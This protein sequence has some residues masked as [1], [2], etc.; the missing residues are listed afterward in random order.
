VKRLA[1]A[2]L[3]GVLLWLA[4]A[5]KVALE[6]VH[7]GSTVILELTPGTGTQGIAA[8]LE[9][10]GVLRSRWPFLAWHLAKLRSRPKLKA[11]EY[12][13]EGMVGFRDV[14]NKI[15]RG[16]ILYHPVSVPEGFNLYDVAAA[17]DRSGLA[18]ADDF[19]AAARNT[20]LIS[21]LAPGASSLEGFLF[22]DTYLFS[23]HTSASQMVQTMVARFRKVYGEVGKGD[24]ALPGRVL[25]VVT[26]ASLVEK[27]TGKPEE[28]PVVAGVFR[29]RLERGMALQ[30][31]PTVVYAALLAGSYRGT[32]YAS[33]LRRSSPYNTYVARGLPPGP[34]SNPGRAALEAAVRPARTDF[35]YFVA[36]SD[37]GHVFSRTLAEH[38]R[39][40]TSYRRRQNGSA[41]AHG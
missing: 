39:R 10:A 19:L 8:Q 31:D 41:H 13:F 22:P 18:K 21:D 40:V 38:N 20:A 23:R 29:N 6:P 1:I 30:C 33:D 36:D 12:R 5:G 14:Y 34:V 27:E 2:I 32:I 37:G 15:V 24:D 25:A 28:R 16:E 7:L 26:L 35:L 17:V 11:G 4:K 9:T 3:I